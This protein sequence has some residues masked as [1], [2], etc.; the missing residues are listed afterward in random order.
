MNLLQN[1]DINVGPANYA[2]LK[3]DE[4]LITKIWY[5]LQGEGPYAGWPAIF[6][7]LAGCNRGRKSDMGCRFCDTAFQFSQG[8][9]DS[10]ENIEDKMQACLSGL[11]FFERPLVVI[12]GGEPMMQ[13]SIGRFCAFLRQRE[14]DHIQIESNGDRLAPEIPTEVVLICSPK[15]VGNNIRKPK[16]DVF[17]RADHFKFLIENNPDSAYY[18]LPEWAHSI[19]GFTTI[20]LSPITVYFRAVEPGE[21]PNLFDT[22]LIDQKATQWNYKR[23]AELC[24]RYGYKASHQSHLLWGLE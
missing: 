5:T 3:E 8:L 21:V 23:V 18:D 19:M 2:H 11:D 14:W 6:I 16:D 12:T 24:M 15:M 13:N 17:L 10:F 9:V 20:W 22:S 4:L 1:V 7:R